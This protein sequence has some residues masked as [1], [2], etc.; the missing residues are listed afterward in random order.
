MNDKGM[1]EKAVSFS[2]LMLDSAFK[3]AITTDNEKVFKEL[4]FLIGFDTAAPIEVVSCMHRNAQNKAVEGPRVEGWERLDDDW[5]KSGY[6]S[7]E[8]II[9]STKDDNLRLTL[10]KMSKQVCIDKGFNH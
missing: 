7:Q 10:R 6:A 3:E 2:D 9:A 1:T 5:I 8:A 4:L